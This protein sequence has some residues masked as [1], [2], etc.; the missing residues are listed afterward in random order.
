MYAADKFVNPTIYFYFKHIHLLIHT[1]VE[2]RSNLTKRG[3]TL[4]L[5]E[6]D[7]QN[8]NQHCYG[9]TGR[10]RHSLAAVVVCMIFMSL[11]SDKVVWGQLV[12]V[13]AYVR[14]GLA[15][16]S[17]I[18]RFMEPTWCTSWA[19]RTQVGPMLAPWTLQS[20]VVCVQERR[21]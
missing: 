10:H 1:H 14:S 16:L 9:N 4:C 12:I 3:H 8:L 7:A 5:K 20:G 11:H 21:R 15:R 17:L 19:D 18:T 13:R 6:G 2:L